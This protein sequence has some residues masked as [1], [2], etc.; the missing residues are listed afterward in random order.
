[1]DQCDKDCEAVGL[2]NGFSLLLQ[3]F[4]SPQMAVAQKDYLYQHQN[5]SLKV[6]YSKGLFQIF[7]NQNRERMEGEGGWQKAKQGRIGTLCLCLSGT[8]INIQNFKKIKK[9]FA[10]NSA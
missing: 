9:F 2:R 7:Q 5:L 8:S 10:D 3:V 1:M 4:F 6:I